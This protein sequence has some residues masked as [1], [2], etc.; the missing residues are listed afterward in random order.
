MYN[1]ASTSIF[2]REILTCI[3]GIILCC[4]WTASCFCL[5]NWLARV[6]NSRCLCYFYAPIPTLGFVVFMLHFFRWSNFFLRAGF[7][8]Y[9]LNY[10]GTDLLKSV[11]VQATCIDREWTKQRICWVTF[12]TNKQINKW[13]NEMPI[14]KKNCSTRTEQ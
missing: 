9:L 11:S 4:L 6:G 13:T 14:N 12:L 5:A 8:L 7:A 1:I 10:R 3:L 2:L